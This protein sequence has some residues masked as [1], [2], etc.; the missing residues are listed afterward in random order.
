MLDVYNLINLDNV[1]VS[2]KIEKAISKTREELKDLDTERMCMVY[3][4][5]LYDNLRR[6]HTICRLVDTNDLG[7]DYQHH[8][9]LVNNG[10]SHYLVDLT[11]NQFGD[12]SW[13]KLLSSGYDVIDDEKFSKYLKVVTRCDSSKTVREA[14]D[15]RI[16]MR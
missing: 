1:A 13:D 8:F 11:Y 12:S 6:E 5:Y 10:E 4:G 15:G 14:F 7:L 9:I 16:K 3:S 2:E